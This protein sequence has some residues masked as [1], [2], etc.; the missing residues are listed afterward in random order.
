MAA[1]GRGPFFYVYFFCMAG[2]CQKMYPRKVMKEVKQISLQVRLVYSFILVALISILLVGSLILVISLRI[3]NNREA[4]HLSSIAVE[5]SIE[6]EH[7]FQEGGSLLSMDYALSRYGLRKNV[8]LRL[9][10]P[11]GKL[12]GESYAITDNPDLTLSSSSPLPL[13]PVVTIDLDFYP[14]EGFSLTVLRF[15]EYFFHPISLLLEGILSAAVAA[16]VGAIF[17]GRFIGRRMARPIIQLSG[18]AASIRDQDWDVIFPETNSRELLDLTISLDSMREQLS[19]SF[20]TLEEERDIMKRFLQDASHQLRTPITALNTFIELLQ[21]D[22]PAMAER[23]TELLDDSRQQVEKLSRIIQ[24]LMELTR[25]ETERSLSGRKIC[26]VKDLSRKAWKG[27]SGKTADKNLFLDLSGPSGEV[28]ADAHRLE[29]A[30]SNILENAVKWSPGEGRISVRISVMNRRVGIRISDQG[31]GIPEEDRARIFE[32]FYQSSSLKGG[33]GLGLAVVKR[34]IED[35]GGSV[36]AGNNNSR[37]A[38][39]ILALPEAMEV[40]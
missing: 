38:W 10:Y 1:P 7:Y 5:T 18:V 16:V 32:R 15:D 14:L 39:F 9:E 2:I 34:I 37:G 36:S 17:M 21:S 13:L 22:L 12:A 29:M 28:L 24:D 26:S 33:S 8:A 3:F 6:L 4:E 35:A 30:L 27:L 40:Q 19:L 11:D 31:P 23:R 20:H 25:I